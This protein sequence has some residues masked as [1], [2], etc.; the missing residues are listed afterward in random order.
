MPESLRLVV[1]GVNHRTAPIELRERIAFTSESAAAA[2]GLLRTKFVGVEVVILSTCNRVEIYVVGGE[3]SAEAMAGFLA[4]FHGVA[5]EL[6]R[7]HLYRYE[8]R[9]VVE[10]LFAVA[11]SLD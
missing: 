6:V 4:E 3:H 2:I 11:S 8:D 7:P 1:V 10:H 9:A 5:V